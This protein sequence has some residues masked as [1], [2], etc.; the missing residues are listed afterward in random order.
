MVDNM[1]KHLNTELEPIG[2]EELNTT[3][4]ML[5]FVETA[6]VS[7][8]NLVAVLTNYEKSK[9]DPNCSYS[10][11]YIKKDSEFLIDII[12]HYYDSALEK[13]NDIIDIIKDYE[14]DFMSY[15]NL[16]IIY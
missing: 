9:F 11:Q 15:Y 8:P 14:K 7:E 12:I 1:L 13:E 2:N 3:T 16:E 4:F 6:E 10:W 5:S